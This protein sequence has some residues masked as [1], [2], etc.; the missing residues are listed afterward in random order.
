MR[1]LISLALNAVALWIVVTLLPG[2]D[3]TPYPFENQTVA[4]IVTY[5]A[6]ALLWGLVNAIIGRFV[7]FISMPLYCLTL[8]LFALIVNGFL[9]WL[10]GWISEQVGYGLSVENFWWAIGGGLLLGLI[11]AVLNGLFNRQRD[12]RGSSRRD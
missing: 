7:K 4:L 9:F 10:V 8:G 12:D 5:L 6:L 11:S 3:V 1:F 2:L